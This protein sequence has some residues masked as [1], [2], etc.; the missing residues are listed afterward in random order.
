[1]TCIAVRPSLSLHIR[2]A[3][4]AMN[5]FLT[6]GNNGDIVLKVE[7]IIIMDEILKNLYEKFGI[8][9]LYA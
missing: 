1:M 8:N 2:R 4:G 5:S 6:S 3:Q 7:F 9:V